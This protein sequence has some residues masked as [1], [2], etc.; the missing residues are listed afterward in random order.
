M[1]VIV[2]GEWAP[3]P[4]AGDATAG[5]LVKTDLGYFLIDCGSGV[6]SELLRYISLKELKAVIITHYHADHVA[7]LGVLQYAIMV[8]RK[9][10]NRKEPLPVYA[11]QEPPEKFRQVAYQEHVESFRVGAGSELQIC[12][13]DVTFANTVHAVPCLAV[14]VQYQ[15]KKFVF[16][17]DTGPSQIV[18]EFAADADLLLSEAS[19]LVKDQG[20]ASVGHLTTHQ[21]AELAIRANVKTLCLTHIY[22]GY[23]K[24]DLKQEAEEVFGR[25]VLMAEKGMVLRM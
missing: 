5:Y 19:W 11:N 6:I 25:N 23:E 8:E 9:L 14:S 7:D 2:L 20:P 13:A 16:T 12:G 1:E 24:E 17:G 21:A 18:E 22:P 4:S 15:N 10:G 3:Y